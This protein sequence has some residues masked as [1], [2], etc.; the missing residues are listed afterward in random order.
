MAIYLRRAKACTGACNAIA[1]QSV[2]VAK[3][4][5]EWNEFRAPDFARL[6]QTMRHRLVIDLRNIH[7]KEELARPAFHYRPA[8]KVEQAFA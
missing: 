6:K 8:R 4:G 3:W 5:E 2:V 7:R 1:S